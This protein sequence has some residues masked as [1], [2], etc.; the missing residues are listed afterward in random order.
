MQY[1]FLLD[2]DM[3]LTI[4]K[5]GTHHFLK[6]RYIY[7]GSAKKNILARVNR[8]IQ[9]E[10]VSRWHFDYLRPYGTITDVQSYGDEIAECELAEF[11]TSQYSASLP[12]KK[13]G[14]SDC[15]C[16]SHLLFC[17]EEVKR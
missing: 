1:F 17:G 4:G 12:M 8:H 15:R 7:V 13:F 3:T 10:K 16:F 11:L 6:G 5:L 9:V 2:D 14:S